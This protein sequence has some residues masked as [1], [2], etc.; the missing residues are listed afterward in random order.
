MQKLLRRLQDRLGEFNDASVQQKTLLNYWEKKKT[1]SE[2]AMGLG[3]LV[4]ILYHR[5]QKTRCLI[6]Q[7]LEGFCGGS[8]AATF[9]HTFKLPATVHVTNVPRNA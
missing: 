5:Q 7:A 1:G 6:V 8:T 3:G 9:K 2:V 4:A